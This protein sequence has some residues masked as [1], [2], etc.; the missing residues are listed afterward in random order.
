VP[1]ER[2]GDDDTIGVMRGVMRGVMLIDSFD[3]T[4]NSVYFLKY[5]ESIISKNEKK[6]KKI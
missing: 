6:Q 5:S 4:Y 1:D 3:K 2:M